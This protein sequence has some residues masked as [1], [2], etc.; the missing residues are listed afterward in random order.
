MSEL[1]PEDQNRISR[2]KRVKTMAIGFAV[3]ITLAI[4]AAIAANDAAIINIIF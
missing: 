2:A 3:A 4:F 1:L